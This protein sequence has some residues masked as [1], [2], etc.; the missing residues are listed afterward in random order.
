MEQIFTVDDNSTN[1][2][3]KEKAGEV[4]TV[5]DL[6]YI[7]QMME[8]G[9]DVRRGAFNVA[10]EEF[11]KIYDFVLRYIKRKHQLAQILL[12]T[13][14]VE[15]NDQS[16]TDF[17]NA[18]RVMEQSIVNS[19]R[20]MDAGT[21]YSNSQYVVILMDT[22][23]EDGKMVAERVIDKFRGEYGENSAAISVSYTIQTMEPK[24]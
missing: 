7:S 13:L 18:M 9:M 16:G 14:Q 5:A 2:V 1:C 21:R 17:E 11:K 4:N 6:E 19:L 8:E 23:M 20:S 3:N 24:K 22:D 15:E 12:F 10:Y